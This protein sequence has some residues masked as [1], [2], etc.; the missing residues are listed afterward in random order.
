MGQFMATSMLDVMN[1][2]G[3]DKLIGIVTDNASNMKNAWSRKEEAVPHVVCHGCAAH[4]NQLLLGG[5]CSLQSVA[6][7]IQR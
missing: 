6:D 2:I 5:I 7:I 1:E 3:N 4:G